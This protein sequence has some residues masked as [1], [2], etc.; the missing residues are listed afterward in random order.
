M[1]TYR[2]NV[3]G[4]TVQHRTLLE[5]DRRY[6]RAAHAGRP[7]ALYIDDQCAGVTNWAN[8]PSVDAYTRE[9]YLRIMG[10]SDE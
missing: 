4:V 2:T 9:T 7:A 10:A 3:E 1:T 5:A 8:G 6:L